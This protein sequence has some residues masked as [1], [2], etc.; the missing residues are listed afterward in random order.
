MRFMSPFQSVDIN[1]NVNM[2]SVDK[3]TSIHKYKNESYLR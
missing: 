3:N 2:A 1:D